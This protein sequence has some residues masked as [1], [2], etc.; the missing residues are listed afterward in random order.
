MQLR[1]IRLTDDEKQEL[2]ELTCLL[3]EIKKA[4]NE[5]ALCKIAE[6]INSSIRDL[7]SNILGYI[8]AEVLSE[9]IRDYREIRPDSLT[10]LKN[11]MFQ[12]LEE[13]VA[14]LSLK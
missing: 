7:L 1:Q 6:R 10:V 8:D 13:A 4:P 9:T 3:Q 2:E 11:K 5:M 14:E 12:W